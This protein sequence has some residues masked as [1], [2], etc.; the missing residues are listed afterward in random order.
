MYLLENAIKF[1]KRIRQ[2]NE[3]I[4]NFPSTLIPILIIYA[5]PEQQKFMNLPTNHEN[6]IISNKT[7]DTTP[8]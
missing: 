5:N 8:S 7:T 1:E 2:F 6:F 3:Q 4:F